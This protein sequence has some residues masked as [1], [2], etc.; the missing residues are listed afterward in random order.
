MNSKFKT[1]KRGLAL[2]LKMKSRVSK[3]ILILGLPAA[4]LPALISA[5]LRK[6]T[7]FLV[8]LGMGTDM[9]PACFTLFGI[10]SLLFLL[11]IVYR[12]L[13]GYT[14]DE[15]V[16]LSTKYILK[17][18][19]R[20]KCEVK[21]PYIENKDNFYERLE[22]VNQFANERLIE[23]ITT[24]MNLAST[25]ITFI[26]VLVLLWEINPYIVLLILVVSFPA[27]WLTYKQNQEQFFQELGWGETGA[28]VVHYFWICT[29][30]DYIQDLRHYNLY[31]Y[32]RK[33]WRTMAEEHRLVKKSLLIKF[34]F[35]NSAADILRSA[36]YLGV[37]TL[38]AWQVF[39]NPLLGVGVFTLVFSLTGELQ[40]AASFL[41]NGTAE[42]INSLSYME[43]Y[44]Y[45]QDLEREEQG[46]EKE[47]LNSGD[48]RFQGVSFTYPET[49][50]EV[51]H[52][53]SVTIHDGEKIAI[54]GENGSGKSTFIS[55]LCGMLVP[56]TGEILVGG[57]NVTEDTGKVRNS[58]S[59][60]FQNFAHY[61]ETLRYNIK[62]SDKNKNRSD[63]EIY[64]L[65]S[66]IHMDDF[67]KHQK[68]GLDTKLG[69]FADQ[70][71]NLSG[72]QWQKIAIARAVYRD[73][74]RI[75]IL[76]EPTSALD[77]IAEA[78]LYQDFSSMTGD[79]TTLLISHRLGITSVVDRILV[80][81]DGRIVEDGSHDELMLKK[82]V[83]YGMYE[84]Q[85]QWYG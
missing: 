57:V 71:N 23:S 24:V 53:I 26:S 45:I 64:R 85:A 49:E 37:L 5:E 83:Y 44:F 18:S 79:K 13:K 77:P 63:E 58:L 72:G 50:R 61:E 78:Q 68:D 10:L 67:V 12:S 76:D 65:M 43:E 62:I 8:D 46:E 75:M 66:L 2:S 40:N 11:Q 81:H 59:V 55:L 38:T 27:A 60:V 41:L 51:L 80:F 4:F 31:S 69:S 16:V 34:F 33:K 28:M 42:F 19:L 15:D 36:V 7:D 39:Q 3:V 9:L 84:A 17:E 25:L 14:D 70:G 74:G 29:E 22:R 32:L 20:C 21:Y 73:F 47:I 35:V 30:D 52:D 1:V 6:L 54:V 56:N 82:G 48:I